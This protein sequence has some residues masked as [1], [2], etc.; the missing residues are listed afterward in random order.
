M[1]HS[2]NRFRTSL[3]WPFVALLLAVEG[4]TQV[5]RF[6]FAQE[7]PA[8]AGQ[9]ADVKILP[10]ATEGQPTP[11][12]VPRSKLQVQKDLVF[13][14]VADEEVA[15]DFYRPAGD[16]VLPLVVMIHGGGW[17]SGDKW[18]VIDHAKELARNGMAV[19]AINYRLA[20]DHR[21]PAQLEDCRKALAWA[22]QRASDWSVDCDR[23][24]LWGYSAGGQLA[25]MLATDA[26]E[27][28][29][30]KIRCLVAGGAPND[31]TYIPEQSNVLAMVFGGSRKELPEVYKNASP[32]YRLN[33]Q[34]PPA[35]LFH[36]TKDLLVPF[37][38]S[39]R[40]QER[41][42][43][44]G[45]D[46]ELIPIEGQG[47]LVTFLHPKGRSSA[48]EFLSKYLKAEPMP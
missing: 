3:L 36:G 26:P 6:L 29:P 40:F 24:G 18:N 16:R 30:V 35:L 2:L 17:I 45:V 28:H 7:P 34:C 48:I 10:D 13:H 4:Q 39:V 47:H 1:L 15:A 12:S 19:L 23:V 42:K 46:C 31:L 5:S 25:S 8:L 41:A 33:A 44:V 22:A 43:E 27:T 32:I 20:P 9:S 14:E 38:T 11:V 37:D 21:Y